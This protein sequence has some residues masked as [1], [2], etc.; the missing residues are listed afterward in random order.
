MQ[1]Y[2]AKRPIGWNVNGEFMFDSIP[3]MRIP[4][5]SMFE[6]WASNCASEQTFLFNEVCWLVFFLLILLSLLGFMQRLLDNEQV[7]G[8][9]CTHTRQY[10][11]CVY[12]S[13]QSAAYDKNKSYYSFRSLF[14]CFVHS[15]N[16][17]NEAIIPK[18]KLIF[19]FKNSDFFFFLNFWLKFCILCTHFYSRHP[20]TIHRINEYWHETEIWKI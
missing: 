4:F 15:F 17:E 11:Q 8:T 3:H 10:P 19:T 9:H 14:Q 2:S 1:S 16:E 6:Q 20:I 5:R 18:L 7:Q 12:R 13:A